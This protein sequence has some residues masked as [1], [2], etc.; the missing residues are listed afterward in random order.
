[1]ASSLTALPRPPS[2]TLFPYTT[3]F[4]SLADM[5]AIRVLDGV[6]SKGL[7][8]DGVVV[9]E[10]DHIIAESP[11]GWRTLYVVLTRA[12]QRLTT[13]GTTDRKSTRLNSS[14]VSISY[15][16]FCLKKK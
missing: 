13:V 3:L 10:P 11:T 9:V 14:H 16:V 12:T 4:R 6:H 8:F 1:L 5:S 7:E 2:S 15:A